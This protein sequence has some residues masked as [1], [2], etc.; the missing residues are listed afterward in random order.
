MINFFKKLRF[1]HLFKNFIILIPS[2]T[3][4]EFKFKNDATILLE[5][6]IVISL[7]TLLCYL[8]NDYFDQN[9]DKINK[10]KKSY[11]Y[12]NKELFFGCV[13]FQYL[14]YYFQ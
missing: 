3:I 7:I 4:A 5:G 2:V 10:L 9:I 6:F 1:N 14:S 13:F 12:S 11:N 8:I